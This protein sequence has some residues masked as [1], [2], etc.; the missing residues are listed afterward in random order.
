MSDTWP[1]RA[2][3]ASIMDQ[4][5]TDLVTVSQAARRLG[6]N[7]SSVSRQVRSLGLG[8]D[9]LGRFSLAQYHAA[10]QADLNPLMRRRPGQATTLSEPLSIDEADDGLDDLA[11]RASAPPSPPP[12]P[13]AP[14]PESER[15]RGLVRAHAAHKTLQAKKLQIE[16]DKEENRLVERT[17]VR[18]AVMDGSRMLR[19]ALLGLPARLAG[20]LAGMTD[21]GEIRA[22]LDRHIRD[23]LATLIEGFRTLTGEP[24][25]P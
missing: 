19:D 18:A 7:K 20:D 11:A 5:T 10:R 22:L 24:T 21:A 15:G 12:P 3:I 23:Q 25:N 13:V 8:R 6:L 17:A 4:P 16:I 2:G 9:E 14:P 1:V